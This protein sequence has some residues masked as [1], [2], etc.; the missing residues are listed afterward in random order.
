MKQ[1]RVVII[2]PVFNEARHLARVLESIAAQ[3]FDKSRLL[4]IAID[5]DST[6]G[7]ARIVRDWLATTGIEGHV[8][9][10][11]LRRIPIS[12]NAGIA[13][14]RTDDIIARMDAHTVY[15]PTYLQNAVT[16]L[17]SAPEDVACI[18]CAHVPFAGMTPEERLVE[19]LYTNPMG[20]GGADYRFGND[21]RE[22][23]NI[24][25]GVWRPRLLQR[26]GLFNENLE[27]NEDAE[28]S[29]RIRACGYRI[30]RVPLPCRF[31]INRG[32]LA[33]LRQWTRYGYWRAKMLQRNPRSVRRR[34]VLSIAAAVLICPIAFTPVRFVLLPACAAYAWLVFRSRSAGE[35]LPVTCASL[36]FFPVLQF[37]FSIGFLAGFLTPRIAEWAAADEFAAA[38]RT[39]A[40]PSN[41]H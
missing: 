25:L 7:S 28:M 33:T 4:F 23:D 32:V 8:L 24:Y 10:N 41:G 31:I 1:A 30:L 27:A 6:D 29:A 20:L 9:I 36:L 38:S 16:A 39:L 13:Y 3:S 5:G 22:V 14:A 21:V 2:M 26:L 19:A 40:S 18:G 15:E 35:A 11:P 37:G 17:E 12:L 34:H